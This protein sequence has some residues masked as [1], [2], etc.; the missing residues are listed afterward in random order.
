MFTNIPRRKSSRSP[1]PPNGTEAPLYRRPD[2]AGASKAQKVKEKFGLFTLHPS[3]DG[4]R[5][6]EHIHAE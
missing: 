1:R 4:Y 6:Q 3:E 2:A 5:E